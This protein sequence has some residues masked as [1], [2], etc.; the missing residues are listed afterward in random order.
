[1][2]K[3]LLLT[4]ACFLAYQALP[5]VRN[6]ESYRSIFPKEQFYKK[7]KA[8]AASWMLQQIEEDFR[9]FTQIDSE[10]V[11][12]TYEAIGN[13]FSSHY[14]IIN[15]ALYKRVDKNGR[16]SAKD[17]ELEKAIKTLLIY[18]KVP[19]LDFVLCPMDGVPESY[20]PEDFYFTK[21]PDLQ[22]PVLA[23]A[24]RKTAPYVVLI[25]DQFSLS[26][27]WK[28]VLEEILLVD[29][30]WEKKVDKAIWRGGLTDIGIPNGSVTEDYQNCPR[31]KIC[32]LDPELVDAKLPW[33]GSLQFD[34]I[35]RD[36]G[37]WG[38]ARTK[39]EHLKCKYLP[40]LD[41]HMCTYPGYQWRLLSNSLCLKQE[42]DQIQWFYRALEPYV[43]YVPIVNDMSDLT[44]KI[45]WAK[46]HDKEA[47][48]IADRASSFAKGYLMPAD[49][50]LY[51]YLVFQKYAS[52]QQINFSNISMKN[53]KCIQYRKR[54]RILKKIHKIFSE[55]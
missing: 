3:L 54:N 16:I 4:I 39:K 17:T 49:D 23:K 27:N 53:F 43:H 26:E 36:E 29:V 6:G 24:K 21:N 46:E 40:V 47:K 18:A 7:L 55:I 9:G 2:K 14:R 10:R 28:G 44:E 45:Q 51:L 13:S 12:A 1:M 5:I 32:Q 35:L 38:D 15:N 34:E 22:A 50:Y 30:P 37:V 25:P 20:M 11:E 52:L 8:P 31:Y 41:G 19:D 33:A 42:S 48:R